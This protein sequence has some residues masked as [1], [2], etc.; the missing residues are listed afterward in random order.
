M[1]VHNVET[2]FIISINTVSGSYQFVT[3]VSDSL[4]RTNAMFVNINAVR[5]ILN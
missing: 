4:I 3:A 1:Y 2:I 5:N